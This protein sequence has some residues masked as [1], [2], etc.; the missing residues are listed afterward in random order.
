MHVAL[1]REEGPLAQ[2]LKDRGIPVTVIPQ[3][4]RLSPTGIAQLSRHFRSIGADVV[5]SHMYRSNIPATLAARWARVP[6]I[7]GHIHNVDSWDSP[8]QQFV[9]R[10]V[11]R[12]RTRTLAVS[13]AVRQD[14]LRALSLADDRV[15]LLYNGI[16]TVEFAPNAAAREALRSAWG[17]APGEVLLVVPARLHPQKNPLGVLEAFGS[18]RGAARLA[19]VGAGKM[20]E[21]LKAAVEAKGLGGRVFLTGRRDDMAAVYNAADAIVLS[22]LKEGFSNA[23]VEALACARPVIASDVGGNREALDSPAIG[24][25]HNA[26]DT[27]ALTA[28]M[29]QAV[30]LGP[31][32]LAGMGPA[33][34]LRSEVFS[35]DALVENTHQLYG[36]LL[37]RFPS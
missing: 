22:S 2:E 26:G 18:V 33:C 1:I 8:R 6:V 24:W 28:Q 11:S 30:D 3:R 31:E 9:D 34:R 36:T 32:G 29:Q 14:V 10:M 21:E 5:H 25:I 12:L 7:L 15:G 17:I 27:A 23:V 37:G 13:E 35:I 16:D 4:S 19:F 20:E